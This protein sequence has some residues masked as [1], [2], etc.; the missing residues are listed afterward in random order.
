MKLIVCC[1]I[2]TCKELSWLPSDAQG[3]YIFDCKDV[4]SLDDISGFQ[5]A[6]DLQHCTVRKCDGLEFVVSS[7][8]LKR[9][10]NLES[11]YLD[12]LK[13]LNAVFGEVGAVAQSAPLPVGTFSSLQIINVTRCTKIKKLLSLQLLRYIWNL[14]TIEVMWCDQMEEITW[15]EYEGENALEKLTLPK[16]ERLV[17]KDLPALKRIYS[18]SSTVLIYDSIKRVEIVQ[19]QEIK[20]VFWF[21]KDRSEVPNFGLLQ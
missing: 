12:G 3:F 13:N 17:L 2:D 10:Q 16:L 1:H 21:C 14:Q 6:T 19:C 20:I 11:L 4:R 18:G 5:D 9:L 15:S 8:C 7:S